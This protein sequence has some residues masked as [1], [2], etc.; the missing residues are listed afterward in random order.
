VALVSQPTCKRKDKVSA[1]AVS[2]ENHFA[3]GLLDTILL[4]N[5][6]I[7]RCGVLHHGW[8]GCML[9]ESIL[10]GV[11]FVQDFPL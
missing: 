10:D 2:N 6:C 11:H 3:L 7:D 4:H 1:R 8:K 5:M 9:E